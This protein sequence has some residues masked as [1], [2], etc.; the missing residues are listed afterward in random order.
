MPADDELFT[1]YR[2]SFDRLRDV[3]AEALHHARLA[4]QLAVERREIIRALIAAGFSQAD[5]ARE[6]DVSRQAIQKMLA[7]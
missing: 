2:S 5:V 4:R 1:R 3:R 6:L 7:V